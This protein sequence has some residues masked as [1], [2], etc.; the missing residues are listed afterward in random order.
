MK[1]NRKKSVNFYESKTKEVSVVNGLSVVKDVVIVESGIDKANDYFD[2][3][4]LDFIVAVGN[5]ATTGIKSRG[6]HPNM[7]KDSLGTYIGDFFN[8]RIVGDSTDAD[9]K[10]LSV[11]AD[12]H[13][14]NIAKSTLINGMS[15]HDFVVQMAKESPDKFGT[16][17]VFYADDEFIEVNSKSV[18]R[19]I[20]TDYKE[21]DIVD[22]PCATDG[23]F[24]SDEDLGVKLTSFLD[25]NPELF[26][27]LEKNE[28]AINIFGKKYAQHLKSKNKSM[29]KIKTLFAGISKSLGLSKDITSTDAVSGKLITIVTE[30]EAPQVGDSVLVDG[31]VAQDGDYTLADGQSITVVA[32]AI[33]VIMPAADVAVPEAPETQVEAIKSINARIDK[34]EKANADSIKALVK[35]NED[36]FKDFAKGIEETL[37]GFAKSVKSEYVPREE[38]VNRSGAQAVT[39]NSLGVERKVMATKKPENK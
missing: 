20:V 18:N 38:N 3:E 16:S 17:I 36:N 2:K 27:A 30:N 4:A 11:I 22:S 26:D 7:C 24:K 1:N 19:L 13:I 15:T 25:E 21:S 29:S 32:G 34:M 28:N 14:A 10:G 35:S 12:L 23:F 33:T 31:E 39:K 37:V 5:A 8:Y 9:G 6:G